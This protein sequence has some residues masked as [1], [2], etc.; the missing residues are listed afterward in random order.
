MDYGDT[1][2]GQRF[3]TSRAQHFEVFSRA[4]T[5]TTATSFLEGSTSQVLMLGVEAAGIEPLPAQ[6]RSSACW[7]SPGLARTSRNLS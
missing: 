7:R 5:P 6:S 1:Y 4:S 2:G 3:E